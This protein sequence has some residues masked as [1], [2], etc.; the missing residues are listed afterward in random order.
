MTANVKYKIQTFV[1]VDQ[2][3]DKNQDN[4]NADK[5]L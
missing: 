3:Q 2:I 5:L 4:S 1:V